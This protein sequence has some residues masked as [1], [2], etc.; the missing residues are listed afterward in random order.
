MVVVLILK[1][2]GTHSKGTHSKCSTENFGKQNLILSFSSQLY[3]IYTYKNYMY[4]YMCPIYVQHV[5]PDFCGTKFRQGT[6]VWSTNVFGVPPHLGHVKHVGIS[7]WFHHV[8]PVFLAEKKHGVFSPGYHL[9]PSSS[10]PHHTSYHIIYHIL[11]YHIRVFFVLCSIP[12]FL[13]ELRCGWLW[14]I[15]DI[16][17]VQIPALALWL[18]ENMLKLNHVPKVFWLLILG[19]A[20]I[21]IFMHYCNISWFKMI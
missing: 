19:S 2:G 14:R 17:K 8:Y 3:I 4:I 7:P 6:A 10:Y 20:C 18:Q 16:E 13:Y 21:P 9:R 5:S 15:P 11:S 12:R 1:G